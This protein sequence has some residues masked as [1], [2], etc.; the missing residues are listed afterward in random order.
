MLTFWWDGV[1]MVDFGYPGQKRETQPVR[2]DGLARAKG[3]LPNW[4]LGWPLGRQLG[5]LDPGSLT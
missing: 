5:G 1:K 3:S 2:R 4:W